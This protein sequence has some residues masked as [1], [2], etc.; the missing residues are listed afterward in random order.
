MYNT[1]WL[2]HRHFYVII[3][4]IIYII[5]VIIFTVINCAQS[6]KY[7]LLFVFENI[8]YKRYREIANRPVTNRPVVNRPQIELL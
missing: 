2:Y 5:V 6:L 7:V 8:T 4:I 3:I 1:P